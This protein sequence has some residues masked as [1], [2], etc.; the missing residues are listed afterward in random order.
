MPEAIDEYTL[1]ACDRHVEKGLQFRPELKFS[2]SILVRRC[3]SNSPNFEYLNN[4]PKAR[5]IACCVHK[6][7]MAKHLSWKHVLTMTLLLLAVSVSTDSCKETAL[8]GEAKIESIPQPGQTVT[9]PPI[10]TA[11][12]TP[13]EGRYPAAIFTTRLFPQERGSHLKRAIESASIPADEV[14]WPAKGFVQMV[15]DGYAGYPIDGPVLDSYPSYF[16]GVID[17]NVGQFVR[18]I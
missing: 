16:C 5:M 10:P 3:P 15:T 7:A 9:I 2:L 13:I 1:S 18:I 6:Q 11:T 8:F 12:L 14:V 17:G 4:P